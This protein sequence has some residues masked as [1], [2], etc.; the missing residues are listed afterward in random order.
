MTGCR[1]LLLGLWPSCLVAS[2]HCCVWRRVRAMCG[3][4]FMAACGAACSTGCT[5]SQSQAQAGTT[6][7]SSSG[8][9]FGEPVPTALC[10]AA[11]D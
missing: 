11:T 6:L 3:A 2:P 8:P 10:F 5:G 4:G 9:V 7:R 1:L